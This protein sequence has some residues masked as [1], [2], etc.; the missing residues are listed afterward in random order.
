M[1]EAKFHG[2][3]SNRCLR[4]LTQKCEPHG[5]ARVKVIGIDPLGTMNVC[6]K[7]QNQGR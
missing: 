2:N 4:C 6:E 1:S 5:G 7:C 3:P